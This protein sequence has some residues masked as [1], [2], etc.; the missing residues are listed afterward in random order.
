[1]NVTETNKARLIDYINNYLNDNQLK[2]IELIIDIINKR[3]YL[4]KNEMI[5]TIVNNTDNK[6]NLSN[7]DTAY[8][9]QY[10][11]QIREIYPNISTGTFVFNY[12]RNNY[13]EL[14]NIN[15]LFVDTIFKLCR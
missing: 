9:I 4:N 10:I 7:Y 2:C 1:M 8:P 6:F 12:S 14:I 11:Q 15:D 5:K 13:G 3:G